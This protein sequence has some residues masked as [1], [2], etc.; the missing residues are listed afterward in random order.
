MKWNYFLRG[1]G[2]GIIMSTLIL[3]ISYRTSQSGRSV[4]EQ[5]K[6]LGMVFPEGTQP[7]ETV[8][9]VLP[10]SEP[11][12]EVQKPDP[13][14]SGAGVTG[15]VTNEPDPT[16]M[17]EAAKPPEPT[18]IPQPSKTPQPAKT[19]KPT[20]KPTP[21]R[22]PRPTKKPVSADGSIQFK[23]R[24]GLLSSTVAREMREAGVISNDKKF[25]EYLEK[26]GYAKKIREG[27]YNIPKGASYEQIARII[28]RS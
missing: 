19:P 7:P 14:G 17:P 27:K 5:A 22:K 24:G 28:T 18:K 10:S 1:L 4:V 16:R 15:T 13:V 21:T 11:S 23:V 12:P 6:E 3:C 20:D 8:P 9:S 26:N 2:V 25:D